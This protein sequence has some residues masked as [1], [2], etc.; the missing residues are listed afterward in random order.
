MK[1]P[2]EFFE[3]GMNLPLKVIKVDP[4]NK[5]IV[6]SVNAF[7]E[8]RPADEITEYRDAHPR[9]APPKPEVVETE[10]AA[11]EALPDTDSDDDDKLEDV[12][13]T[14]EEAAETEPAAD[15]ALPDTDSDD[16]DKLEDVEVVAEEDVKEEPAVEAPPAEPVSDEP[17]APVAEDQE[18]EEE[19]EDK[20]GT[21]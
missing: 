2:A 14:A 18:A 10:P 12:E 11:D 16:D 9:K 20:K 3:N 7:F 19:P 13:V 5:R 8:G 17:E 6:L 15:E 1:Q 4:Q 21:E